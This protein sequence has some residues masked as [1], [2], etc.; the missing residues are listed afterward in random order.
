MTSPLG[1]AARR[2]VCR[3]RIGPNDLSTAPAGSMVMIR[4]FDA[5]GV[6]EPDAA[7]RFA[8]ELRTAARAAYGARTRG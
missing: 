1:R 3:R 5:A 4:L 7:R 8:D 2:I 6:V